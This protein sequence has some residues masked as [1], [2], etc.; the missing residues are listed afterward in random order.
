MLGIILGIIL[1]ILFIG[2]G[3]YAGYLFIKHKRVKEQE[4]KDLESECNLKIREYRMYDETEKK[5]KIREEYNNKIKAVYKTKPILAIIMSIVSIVSLVLFMFLPFS[6]RTVDATQVAVAKVW[7]EAEYT[8]TSGTHFADWISTQYIYYPISTQE[9]NNE[10]QAYSQDAQSMNAQLV[11]QYRIKADKAVQITKEYGDNEMLK[12]RIQSIVEE[13]AKS[14]L[15]KKQAMAIIETRSQLSAEMLE[16][17]DGVFDNYYVEITNVV[18][19]NIV[20]SEAFEQAVEDKMIAEQEKLKAE[21]EKEKKV[22]E[23]EALLEVAKKEAEAS[24]EKSKGDA[25]ALKIMQ[26]AWDS[27]SSEVK[28]VMLKQLAIERWDGKLPETM[29]GTEFLEWLMGA[30]NIGV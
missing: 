8:K 13:R 14:V 27:L 30:I 1:G 2:I 4:I 19:N 25:E 9:I 5:N 7:G 10:I 16:E 26:E 24:I 11:V 29:V 28:E 18:I 6:I 3:I 17:M 23:A 21:Y 20:F 12:S 15:S 22:I